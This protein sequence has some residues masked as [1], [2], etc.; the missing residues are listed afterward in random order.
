M[1]LNGETFL[2]AEINGTVVGFCSFKNEEI[3]GLYVDPQNCRQGIGVTLLNA[4]EEQILVRGKSSIK[5][6]AALSALDFYLA[7][8]FHELERKPWRTRGGIE[9]EVCSMEKTLASH[10][11]DDA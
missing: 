8:G 9:I 2:V 10:P 4:A 7:H 1:V 3:V 11:V 5:L 6:N